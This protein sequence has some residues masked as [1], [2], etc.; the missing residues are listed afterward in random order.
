MLFLAVIGRELLVE[1]RGRPPEV[2]IGLQ[3]YTELTIRKNLP[4][5]NDINAVAG[6]S[7]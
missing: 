3:G 2:W 7:E 5:E 4:P 6:S 1:S